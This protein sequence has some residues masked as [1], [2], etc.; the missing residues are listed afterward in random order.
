MRRSEFPVQQCLRRCKFALFA[1][2]L[3]F[4]TFP[5]DNRPGGIAVIKDFIQ[6]LPAFGL[7]F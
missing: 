3:D 7:T 4:D 2:D 6:R 1:G 5:I